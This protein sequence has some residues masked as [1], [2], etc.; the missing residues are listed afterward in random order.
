MIKTSYSYLILGLR[1]KQLCLDIFVC[2]LHCCLSSFY[3]KTSSSVYNQPTNPAWHTSSLSSNQN[4]GAG[5]HYS[6]SA[7]IN[8]SMASPFS[9]MSNENTPGVIQTGNNYPSRQN[10]TNS[11]SPISYQHNCDEQNIINSEQLQ[12]HNNQ[13]TNHIY[14]RSNSAGHSTDI[15]ANNRH[16]RE[17]NQTYV[18]ANQYQSEQTQNIYHSSSNT[19]VQNA[20]RREHSRQ[21]PV[22]QQPVTH[23]SGHG[24]SQLPNQSQSTVF[25]ASG[26]PYSHLASACHTQEPVTP[27]SPQSPDDAGRGRTHIEY[28]PGPY[29]GRNLATISESSQEHLRHPLS[30]RGNH[31]NT[32]PGYHGNYDTQSHG[33]MQ[34]GYHS[35]QNYTSQSM[36]NEHYGERRYEA[37]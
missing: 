17:Y 8:T 1:H 7:N 2:I 33:N 35:N 29:P 36:Q 25:R 24:Y 31:G 20:Y 5:T 21:S 16:N 15:Q 9:R 28:H 11:F 22:P 37:V 26:S 6:N 4:T 27:T 34:H 13:R 18:S 14:G 32:P 10:S 23:S 12:V 19:S 30:P 3:F